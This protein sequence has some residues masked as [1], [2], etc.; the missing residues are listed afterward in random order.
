LAVVAIV[1]LLFGLGLSFYAGYVE[2]ARVTRARHQLYTIQ[3]ACESFYAVRRVYPGS[4]AEL[5]EAGFPAAGDGPF[6]LEARDPWGRPYQYR[7]DDGATAYVLETG[8][9]RVQGVAGR[10]VLATGREGTYELPSVG[11]ERIPGP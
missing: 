10:V 2:N 1:G 9:N 11:E 5:G 8:Y 6:A 3:S 4:A 7:A